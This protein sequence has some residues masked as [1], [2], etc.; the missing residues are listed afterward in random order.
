[1]AEPKVWAEI[2]GISERPSGAVDPV[3]ALEG[4][5]KATILCISDT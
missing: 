2:L 3:A 5:V 1:M 4:E